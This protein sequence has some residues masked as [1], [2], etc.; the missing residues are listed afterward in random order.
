MSDCKSIEGKMKIDMLYFDDCPSWKKGLANLKAALS[1]ENEEE[2]IQLIR[3]ESDDDAAKE[4]FLGSPSFRINGHDVWPEERQSYHPGCRI[5]T[6][7]I[8]MR[9]FPSSDMLR[10]KIHD[11]QD[12]K[13]LMT[14]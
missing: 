9:G 13:L 7:K 5:Y 1:A 12:V 3:V 10:R 4:K 11:L 6:T 2:D 8:G 14:G